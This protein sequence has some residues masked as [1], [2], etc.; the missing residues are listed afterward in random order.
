MGQVALLILLCLGVAI[1]AAAA[2]V[3]RIVVPFAAGGGGDTL[4]RVL[5]P[6]F[7]RQLQMPV[8]IPHSR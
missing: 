3:L 8:V 4:T 7:S 6:E 1:A 5:A 2:P